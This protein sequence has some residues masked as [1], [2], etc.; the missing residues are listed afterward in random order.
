MEWYFNLLLRNGF[1]WDN[2]GRFV[3]T[4]TRTDTMHDTVGIA[5]QARFKEDIDVTNES[6]I[7]NIVT[8]QLLDFNRNLD[9]TSA[10]FEVTKKIKRRRPYEST[11][12]P[13]YLVILIAK[14]KI[15]FCKAIFGT[16]R[17]RM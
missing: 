15:N 7:K 13:D 14:R 9:V 4:M 2:F 6:T 16:K 11:G 1:A 10:S 8:E 3:A 12:L 17:S 5:Y